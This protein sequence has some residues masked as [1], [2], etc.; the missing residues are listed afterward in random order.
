[1]RG[2][3]LAKAWKYGDNVDTDVI[4][5]ARYL[6]TTDEAELARHALED[7]DPA[8]A[9][10]VSHGD[11][12][13]A[14]TNFGCGS[15]RE[16][17]PVSLRGA[18]VGAVIAVSFARIFFRNAINTG[19]PILVCP[20]AVHAI[21]HGDEVAFDASS[22]EIHDVTKG[23]IFQAEPLPGSVLSIV[24]EGGLVPWVRKRMA[25]AR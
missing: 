16:H 5:P 23:A 11:V 2:L 12:V 14:G 1:M 7:L 18:G 17:A 8:F 15:S 10:Q 6:T 25:E 21:D 20:E 19:L 22:G 3:S 4:I 24:A 9:A 13:V